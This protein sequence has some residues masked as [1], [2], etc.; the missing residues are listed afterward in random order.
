MS[1]A[2]VLLTVLAVLIFF[3]VLE[4]VL[5]RMYLTDRM[6]LLLIGLMFAGTLMPNVNIGKVSINLGGAVIPLGV[7]VYL[8]TKADST[9]EI[10]RSLMGMVITGAAVW[11]LSKFLP[12][13]PESMWMEPNLLYGIAAGLIAWLLGRSRRGAFFCGVTGV[14]LADVVTAIINWSAGIDQ[15][16][17][18]GGAGIGD[19]VVLAGVIGVLASEL[20]GEAVERVSRAAHRNR[21][22]GNT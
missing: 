8:L 21:G 22:G 11:G 16:L 19:T 13:E 1:I 5:D 9:A 15:R 17:V 7:S 6:A 10:A 14:L 18:L 4:R 20:L 2:M 3:G 12:D